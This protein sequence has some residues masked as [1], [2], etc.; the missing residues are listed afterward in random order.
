MRRKPIMIPASRLSNTQEL[1]GKPS[2]DGW[3]QQYRNAFTCPATLL[4]HLNL[5]QLAEQVADQLP[6]HF[7]MRVP[8]AFVNRMQKGNPNDPL[9]RQVL[10]LNDEHQ[11][12]DGYVLDPVG[13]QPSIVAQGVLHKYQGRALFITTG[14]CAVHCRYC[15]RR[16]FPYGEETAAKGQFAEA[17]DTVRQDESIHEVLLSGGDP[18]SLS[19]A[20]LR[21]LSDAL[22]DI[23]HVKRLRIHTRLPVVLPDRLTDD[24]LDWLANDAKPIVM[25]LHINHA[26]ELDD[27]LLTRM[28]TLKQTGVWLLNQAVLL[29]GVND[30]LTAQTDL[31]ERL[32][33]AG[34]TPYYLHQLD[35]VQGAAHFAVSDAQAIA[36]HQAMSNALPGYLVPKLVHEQAGEPRKLALFAP[37]E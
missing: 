2:H 21:Q 6:P 37:R 35:R 10:P 20:K 34:I 17:L 15:F 4:A 14:S 12:T 7:G 8:H 16:N 18:L 22:A 32:F 1:H 27:A 24:L 23:K 25:V 28:K 30:D 9:L 19:T 29:R 11:I 5:P 36:L 31:S 13:D 3:R 26:Q 33:E